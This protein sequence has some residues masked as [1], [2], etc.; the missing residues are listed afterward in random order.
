MAQE[1]VWALHSHTSMVMS[2]KEKHV[3]HP[4]HSPFS[5]PAVKPGA[6]SCNY[7]FIPAPFL[8]TQPVCGS[9]PPAIQSPDSSPTQL[10]WA[11]EVPLMVT[12]VESMHSIGTHNLSFLYDGNFLDIELPFA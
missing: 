11:T 7:S 6:W 2:H 5:L 3:H 8:S 12:S 1:R 9:F 4:E 10:I